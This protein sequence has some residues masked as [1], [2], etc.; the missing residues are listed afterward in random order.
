MRGCVGACSLLLLSICLLHRQLDARRQ[1]VSFLASTSTT[2]TT[3]TKTTTSQHSRRRGDAP[4]PSIR[5]PNQQVTPR[6]LEQASSFALSLPSS[7]TST[8]PRTGM[9][10]RLPPRPPENLTTHDEL[11]K[12]ALGFF[13]FRCYC[14]WGRSVWFGLVWHACQNWRRGS[15]HAC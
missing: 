12:F 14:C 4:D 5:A 8:H 9:P 2:T 3:A 6:P 11:R 13:L 10:P 7:T 15:A 1:S